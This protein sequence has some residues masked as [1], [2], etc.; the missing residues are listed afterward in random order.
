[1]QF[2]E[3][4]SVFQGNESAP[5]SLSENITDSMEL[6]NSRETTSCEATR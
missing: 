2:D 5:A 4:Q 6:S 3:N 1:M